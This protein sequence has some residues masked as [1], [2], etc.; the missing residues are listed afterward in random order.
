MMVDD[1]LPMFLWV[2]IERPDTPVIR[3]EVTMCPF[4]IAVVP[5]DRVDAHL[6]WHRQFQSARDLAACR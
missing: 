3:L 1:R 5:A 2:S 4:C 6:R